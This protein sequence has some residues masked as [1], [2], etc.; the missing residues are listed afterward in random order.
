MKCSDCGKTLESNSK[1]CT[2]CGTQVLDEKIIDNKEKHTSELIPPKLKK[3]LLYILAFI[4]TVFIMMMI[5]ITLAINGLIPSSEVS[6][7]L[8]KGVPAL[9]FVGIWLLISGIL[10]KKSRKII[11]GFIWLAVV[12]VSSIYVNYNTTSF[13][14]SNNG[15]Y[16]P[17]V[18]TKPANTRVQTK[19]RKSSTKSSNNG[20]YTFEVITIPANTRVQ[21]MNIKPKYYDGIQLK[22]GRYNV[23][24]SKPGYIT[25]D[26]YIDVYQ[27]TVT[28]PI[29]LKKKSSS[30]NG[31]KNY[32]V[33][34]K[35]NKVVYKI[36]DTT[37]CY[38]TYEN[39]VF[40][41]TCGYH[42]NSKGVKIFCTK[43]KNVCKTADEI[44]DA[45][46]KVY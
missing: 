35:G 40:D 27:D 21:I 24:I 33:Y 2:H 5:K 34:R 26:Y 39:G 20:L 10:L 43:A 31:D 23:R 1:F 12:I 15:L 42:I 17:E 45:M 30:G 18:I 46:G 19:Q 44:R 8:L 29:T 36:I 9:L 13:D 32:K 38:I 37:P 16:T 41:K 7:G 25:G 22:K 3:V 4:L 28:T 11:W 14:G 6:G